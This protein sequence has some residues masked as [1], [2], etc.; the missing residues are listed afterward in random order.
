MGIG[1]F[2]PRL[3]AQGNSVRGI[4]VCQEL[5]ERFG[6][7]LFNSM[8]T[9][10]SVIRREMNIQHRP[11]SRVRPSDEAKRLKTLG[12]SVLL[13][14]LQGDLHFSALEVVQRYVWGSLPNVRI[15]LLDFTHVDTVDAAVIDALARLTDCLS[16]NDR[17]V[18]FS[19]LALDEIARRELVAQCASVAVYVDLDSALEAVEESLLLGGPVGQ[20][21]QTAL[22]G[23][24]SVGELDVAEFLDPA[25]LAYFE[26]LLVRRRIDANQ[27]ICA[28]GD[29]A[30]DAYFLARGEVSIRIYDGPTTFQRLA[31]FAPGT[32]FG[33]MSMIDRGA[34]SA[35]VWSET[36]VELLA[37]SV[38]DFD[39]LA[40]DRPSL[41]IKLLQYFIRTLTTRLR[42]ANDLIG[43]LSG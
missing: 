32:V 12:E 43:Q 37:L 10:R 8:R 25:D 15:V 14:E 31:A 38:A 28:R 41:K 18:V 13:L 39:R 16:S 4:Q 1:V 42:R 27:C 3:D 22:G 6:L 17:Q 40:V 35:D 26:R 21:G 11:S 19:G 36:E 29:N 24:L 9:G 33:E 34:R 5:S 20:T 2:S 23:T 30:T 7:H